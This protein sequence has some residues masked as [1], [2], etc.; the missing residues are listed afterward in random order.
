[1]INQDFMMTLTTLFS[2]VSTVLFELQNGTKPTSITQVQ[3]DILEYLYF[4]D[5]KDLS[6][7]SA[8]MYLS[9]P[10]AS[11]EVKKL[12]EKKLLT[13]EH[14]TKDKRRY[15]IRLTQE[16]KDMMEDVL[17]QLYKKANEKYKHMTDEDQARLQKHMD[18]IV[19]ELLF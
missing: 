6:C 8:C 3:F 12:T 10:N 16:G 1:M 19:K 14:D 15:L 7:I 17:N 5:C 2:G 11:R 13:K 9:M 4:N 18:A